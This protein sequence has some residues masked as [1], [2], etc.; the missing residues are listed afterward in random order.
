MASTPPA[1][2][3]AR[4]GPAGP[5]PTRP[6]PAVRDAATLVL[7]RRDGPRPR[8]LMGQRGAGAAF[9]PSLFVFPGGAVEPGDLALAGETPPADAVALAAGGHPGAARALA[10]GAGHPDAAPALTAGAGDP[11]AARLALLAAEAARLAT[12]ADPAVARALPFAAIRELWE[13]TGLRLGRTDPAAAA[14][15]A[16]A[17][18][19]WAGF[20]ASG[21][22]PRTE[23]LTFVFRAVTPPGRPR[24]FDARFFLAEATELA[25]DLDAFE[26]VDH[27]LSQLQWIDV[28]AARALPLPFITTVVLA[29]VEARLG[30][31]EAP[32][33]GAPVPFFLHDARGSHVRML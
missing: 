25:S 21:L 15:A 11:D 12:E 26:R 10:A 6:G 4:P 31:P 16:A 7:V 1:V 32:A 5:E 22:T 18:A 13:E 29:E 28:E 9:M 3:E 33:A 27:E 19:N 23:A 30:A 14:R 17:P 2:P 20:L 8:V 24:R